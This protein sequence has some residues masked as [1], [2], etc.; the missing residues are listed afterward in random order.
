MT[1][2]P[3]LALMAALACAMPAAAAPNAQL[4]ASV[5]QRLDGLGFR[6][7][8]AGTLTTRQIAALHLQLTSRSV[9]FGPR[10]IDRRA[11][12]KAILRWD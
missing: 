1:L 12:V 10:W 6:H 4:V 2:R 9:G 11:R 5:Q 7:V 3:V 8:N